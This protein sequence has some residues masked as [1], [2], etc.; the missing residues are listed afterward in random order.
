LSVYFVAGVIDLRAGETPH[1]KDGGSW[2]NMVPLGDRRS[3]SFTPSSILF[4]SQA[5]YQDE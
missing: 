5:S 4:A 3:L 1:D 2:Y